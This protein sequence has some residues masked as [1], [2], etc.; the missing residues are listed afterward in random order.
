M[1]TTVGSYSDW[2]RLD[3]EEFV[4]RQTVILELVRS[5]LPALIA[6]NPPAY[7]ID[8][9]GEREDVAGDDKRVF[10]GMPCEVRR[11][12]TTTANEHDSEVI[13]YLLVWH[14]GCDGQSAADEQQKS[15]W[16]QLSWVEIHG[17]SG[18]RIYGP[19]SHQLP[20]N[21]DLPRDLYV[22]VAD[23][24][25]AAS[26]GTRTSRDDAA[27]RGAKSEEAINAWHCNFEKDLFDQL[28]RDGISDG[29]WKLRRE[30]GERPLKNAGAWRDPS[31]TFRTNMLQ[32][33]ALQKLLS[34]HVAN[35]AWEPGSSDEGGLPCQEVRHRSLP[36]YG[37][38][39]FE[40]DVIDRRGL[41]SRLAR[42]LFAVAD[43]AE[44]GRHVI[45]VS[46]SDR[47]SA[48][49]I[50]TFN[51]HL[52]SALKKSLKEP[53][54]AAA[55]VDFFCRT[56]YSDEARSFF[57]LIA[58]G[59]RDLV[60]IQ[61]KSDVDS[62]V[63]TQLRDAGA[64]LGIWPLERVPADSEP[65]VDK[66]PATDSDGSDVPPTRYYSAL[67][68][69]GRSPF[70]AALRLSWDAKNDRP[71]V[72]MLHD[73]ELKEGWGAAEEA[74]G[75][76]LN[77]LPQDFD[78]DSRFSLFLCNKPDEREPVRGVLR[79]QMQ[80]DW[81]ASP[82][83][84]PLSQSERTASGRQ[85]S[86][87]FC[88][89]EAGQLP[90]GPC[91]GE[92]V[93]RDS[94]A[95]RGWQGGKSSRVAFRVH[96]HGR[97][98]L[99]EI[100]ISGSL[101][102]SYSIFEEELLL[103]DAHIEGSLNLTGCSFL[104]G[105]D[106]R[107][108]VIEGNLVAQGALLQR[109]HDKFVDRA[110]LELSGCKVDGD[111]DVRGALEAEERPDRERSAA[112]VRLTGAEIGG[113]LLIGCSPRD[114]S[115]ASSRLGALDASSCVIKGGVSLRG[116]MGNG[117]MNL[118]FDNATI[119]GSLICAPYEQ[120]AIWQTPLL[121]IWLHRLKPEDINARSIPEIGELLMNGARIEGDLIVM[122]SRFNY[123]S[124]SNAEIKG[125]LN[126]FGVIAT[127][128]KKDDESRWP[129][130]VKGDLNARG[131]RIG[132]HFWARGL[133]VTGTLDL[134]KAEVEGLMEI[135]PAEDDLAIGPVD[136]GDS[137]PLLSSIRSE[138][139]KNLQLSLVCCRGAVALMG[140]TVGGVLSMI[141][142]EVAALKLYPALEFP[143]GGSV[144]PTRLGG[145]TIAYS[146][147]HGNLRI[148][149]LQVTGCR[150]KEMAANR[151][152]LINSTE[153]VGDFI[154]WSVG[155][156]R[157]V[158]DGDQQPPK[159]LQAWDFS[160]A[161]WGDVKLLKSDIRGDCL[162]SLVKVSGRI[163]L[164]DSHIHGDLMFGSLHSHNELVDGEDG[165][166]R[167]SAASA[168]Q[169][170]HR[171]FRALCSGFSARMVRA[172]NDVV[173][174]GLV[175]EALDETSPASKGERAQLD[176]S[177]I[178][179]RGDTKLLHL[180]T[181]VRSATDVEGMVDAS[182]A[183]FNHLVFSLDRYL[184]AVEGHL[185]LNHCRIE[186]LE[187]PEVE[188]ERDEAGPARWRVHL[189]EARIQTWKVGAAREGQTDSRPD[190]ELLSRLLEHAPRGMWQSVENYL[191]VRGYD[192]EA[193]RLYRCYRL[194]EAS[195]LQSGED[196][197]QRRMSEG[198]IESYWLR[199]CFVCVPALVIWTVIGMAERAHAMDWPAG[200]RALLAA[201]VVGLLWGVGMPGNRD[202]LYRYVLGYGTRVG[203][204]VLLW[205]GFVVAALP[206]YWS[207]QNIEPSNAGLAGSFR[208]A[209]APDPNSFWSVGHVTALLLRHHV[210][211]V[212]IEVM[213]DWQLKDDAGTVFCGPWQAPAGCAPILQ[214]PAH[215]LSPEAMGTA[216][217]V[218]NWVLWPVFLTFAALSL[219]RR[220]A[221]V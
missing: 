221:S 126:L 110:A 193:D 174:D 87:W 147:I 130:S 9:S 11:R 57:D 172:E 140:V 211:V 166:W 192:D 64:L 75:I 33:P 111:I 191:R 54:N 35:F 206:V 148:P 104:R 155:A 95:L 80:E 77:V 23:D 146:K 65:P 25:K 14:P 157:G 13:D 210:P 73:M 138:I 83:G 162:M 49:P 55:Y 208:M 38:N 15:T 59:K 183:T 98:D 143:N 76:V 175:V 94:V 88:S 51:E 194:G 26:D 145:L 178:S 69:Y 118:K 176:L 213:D 128:G 106:L 46:L 158:F 91:D 185:R 45:A 100:R 3:V 19:G 52:R 103:Q 70:L 41:N 152:I 34:D 200:A 135:A 37:S 137:R 78:G 93:V 108:A 29:S 212:T 161:V 164:T 163:D 63:S 60:W 99:R 109:V 50:H 12:T 4:R 17:E 68:L 136:K 215:W 48:D 61:P 121:R 1:A 220:R 154:L 151:G 71:T 180:D 204:V 22:S 7:L 105:A 165:K 131:L 102:L 85:F 44:G 96:F 86:E 171:H 129:V 67:M 190:L 39:A 21:L 2:E 196:R 40:C 90:L 79:Y 43:G 156:L 142:S 133:R 66:C 24:S 150:N 6:R 116:G 205:L 197:R 20:P 209:D 123:V 141:R 127:P 169:A 177:H 119:G 8:A 113:C 74:S 187:V 92:L 97:V 214:D 160:A 170:A 217:Q 36:F 189:E 134:I 82:C 149:Y 18:L 219:W 216:M 81:S 186:T 114:G 72:R 201:A 195:R 181:D 32:S 153:I 167:Q 203:S 198:H 120:T 10:P 188:K 139:G 84:D 107:G 56:L 144:L 182:F 30:P 132:G 159:H 42:F 202:R 122:A 16:P 207:P 184:R 125:D 168:E 112:C 101:D 179:V 124:F 28:C 47:D 31:K 5:G 89:E 218:V 117:Q 173:L 115:K 58:D 62:G 27:P 53:E 199:T